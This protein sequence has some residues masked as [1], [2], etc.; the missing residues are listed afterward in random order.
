MIGV[1]YADAS[2]L[3]KLI[4]VEPESIA[5]HHW[6]TEADRVTTSRVGIVE[7]L[8]AANRQPHDPTHRDH[9]V[10]DIEVIELDPAIARM[11]AGLGP[12][13]LRT[14]DAIHLATALSLGPDLDAFVTYDDRLAAAARAIGLPVVRPA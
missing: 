10:E 12:G 4:L 2:A 14:L 1:A 6:Y 11:A 5:F 8:R 7:T 9:V 13:T 3:A